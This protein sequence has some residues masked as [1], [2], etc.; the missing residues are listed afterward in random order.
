MNGVSEQDMKHLGRTYSLYCGGVHESNIATR[1]VWMNGCVKV[2][3]LERAF[4][5]ICYIADPARKCGR[6]KRN[7]AVGRHHVLWPNGDVFRR[8]RIRR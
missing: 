5:S 4:A 6:S 1:A 8:M 7:R 3:L 2:V